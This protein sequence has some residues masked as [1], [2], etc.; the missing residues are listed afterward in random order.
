[1]QQTKA[2]IDNFMRME[3]WIFDSPDQGWRGVPAVHALVVPGEPLIRHARDRRLAR[4]DLRRITQPVLNIYGRHHLVPP[5][6][7]TPLEGL[8]GSKDY[9]ALTWMSV[10]LACMSWPGAEGT[11][12]G[13]RLLARTTLGLWSPPRTYRPGHAQRRKS[14]GSVADRRRRHAFGARMLRQPVLPGGPPRTRMHR[15]FADI[16]PGSTAFRVGPANRP[17]PAL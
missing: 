16:A 1:M 12:A 6:A 7:S 11:A 4:S 3:K 13:H 10:T 2:Q 14:G 8:I 15:T 5:S 9:A 17:M